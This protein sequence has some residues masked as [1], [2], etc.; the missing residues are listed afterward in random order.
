MQLLWAGAKNQTRPHL[1]KIFN[2]TARLE[3][4]R[5]RLGMEE[6]QMEWSGWKYRKDQWKSPFCEWSQR[7]D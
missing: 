1:N 7:D 6:E 2:G 4:L 5:M 3:K